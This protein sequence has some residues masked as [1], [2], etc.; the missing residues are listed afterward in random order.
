MKHW[1]ETDHILRRLAHVARNGNRAAI[2]HVVNVDGSAYRRP[3]AKLLIEEHGTMTGGVSGGCLEADVREVALVAIRDDTPTLRHYETGSDADTIWGLGL[4]CNGSVD[5]FVQPVTSA[6]ALE[7]A[8]RI[9][10]LL[11]GDTSFAI[12]TIVAGPVG[13]GRSVVLDERRVLSGSTSDS[14]L[15]EELL[16]SSQL[17]LGKRVSRL[18]AVNSAQVFTDV[19]TPPPRLVIFGA[20]DDAIPLAA[21][22]SNVGFRV[23]VVDHRPAHLAAE[24][25]PD[26]S[27]LVQRQPEER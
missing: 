27:S 26:A 2:A 16:R 7:V 11:A 13:V 22:A 23:T 12:A 25:F 1:Q 4:G 19:L 20:G 9:R 24:R 15:D 8:E 18:H 14:E 10:E 17:I 3:G 5:V 6:E 21:N